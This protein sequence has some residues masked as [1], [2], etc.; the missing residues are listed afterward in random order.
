[1]V[2]SPICSN[3][4]CLKKH[5]KAFIQNKLILSDDFA[6]TL[7]RWELLLLGD[8]VFSLKPFPSNEIPMPG[9]VAI[10]GK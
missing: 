3:G 4:F 2:Y 10:A 9:Q 6:I 7:K 1:M 5:E 8:S